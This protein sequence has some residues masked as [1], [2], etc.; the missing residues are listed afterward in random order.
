MRPSFWPGCAVVALRK[1]CLGR[2][3]L[4]GL[5]LAFL[6]LPALAAT[7]PGGVAVA[8]VQQAEANGDGGD[9]VLQQDAP[10]YSG[11][12]IVT[13]PVGQAQVKF[14][15]N[16]KLVVGPNS[17]LVIDAFVF[18]SDDTARRLSI[19]ALKGAFRFI[20]GNSNHDAYN[21]TT[22]TATIGVRGTA[23]D[24]HVAKDGTTTIAMWHGT[25]RLCDKARPRRCTEISGTCS[26]VQLAPRADFNRVNDVYKRTDI[27]DR[28]IPFA[29]RQA[30]LMSEFRVSSGG[31][32]IRNVDPTPNPNSHD[33]TPPRA[34][35]PPPPPPDR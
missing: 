15:D 22:P 26:M 10:V 4:G 2:L 35:S 13:G 27:L 30:R 19:D 32:A 25:V 20:S 3:A 11:D 14:R 21:I 24:G 5:S 33:N 34:P 18:N 23:F 16:T 17:R 8:V 29:F 7:P 9:R 6:S 31:C 12:A 1:C 28:L